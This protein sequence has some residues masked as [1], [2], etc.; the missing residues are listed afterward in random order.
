[1]ACVGGT[2]HLG[3]AV[4]PLKPSCCQW[5]SWVLA[6]LLASLAAS[7]VLSLMML[8]KIPVACF[9]FGVCSDTFLF[10]KRGGEGSYFP[11]GVLGLVFWG[12]FV[13]TKGKKTF[14]MQFVL[15]Q[16]MLCGA[17]WMSGLDVERARALFSRRIAHTVG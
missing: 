15:N 17:T 13:V 6:M 16:R 12:G 7:P 4:H 14:S 10:F 11:V 1:M 3:A 2:A 8:L 5:R 9:S